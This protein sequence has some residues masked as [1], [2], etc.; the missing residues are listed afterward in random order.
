M[1]VRTT[2]L[3]ITAVLLA[4][5]ACSRTPARPAVH[6]VTFNEDIAPILY[7]HCATCH[8]PVNVATSPVPAGEVVCFAGAPFSV[9]AYRD[10]APHA[11][12]IAAA[13][14]RRQMPPWLP[15]DGYGDFAGARR[16]TDEQIATLKQWAEQGAPEGDPAHRPTP[17]S[18]PDGWQLG[19]PDL[20]VKTPKPFIVPAGGGD[21]FRNFVVP[22]PI[23]MTRYVRGIE[24]RADNPRMVHHASIGVDRLRVSRKLDGRD[25]HPGFASMPD[26]DDVQNVYGWSPGKAP[27]ME[28]AEQAWTLDKGSDLVVQMHL[29]PS[30]K[31]QTVR[32]TLALFFSDTPP[33]RAPFVIRL[34][35][36]SIDIPAGT[37]DYLV[38]DEYVLPAD[39]DAISIYPHAHYLARDMQAIA[40]LPDGTKRWLLWIKQWD[41]RWQDQYH[42]ATPVFLPAGTRLT[43]RYTYDNSAANPRN[44]HHPPER[45]KWGPRSSDEMAALWLEVQPRHKEDLPALTRDYVERAVRVDIAGAEMQVQMTPKDP[46][47]HNYLATKY[48]QARR[49]DDA[50]AQLNEA[51]HLNARDA[52]AHSNLSLAYEVQGKTGDALR[53][54]RIAVQLEPDDD[55]V[56]YNLANV[57][58]AVG[59]TT[60]AID[61]F[62]R[63]VALNPDNADAQFNLG[64]LLGGR[65]Q[66]ADA[67]PHLRRAVA[68]NPRN[69]DAHR[70]LGLALALSGKL[71]DGI[72]EAREAVSLQPDSAPA[73]QSLSNL[74]QAK[75]ASRR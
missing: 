68:L 44:L 4:A 9:L 32:P 60:E 7:D 61:E 43:M 16:L 69:A 28:P 73:Q 33:A 34:E 25:G 59:A 37:P 38:Q 66:L 42:Y 40:T 46:L 48:L 56:H 47:A 49:V 65:G 63:A 22:V 26:D 18:L 11:K 55:R 10:V 53:E 31:P 23:G 19:Q 57:L 75:A 1:R 3:F 35:S 67:V 64:V 54:A 72:A 74:L 13:V 2:L 70:N 50:I 8:R 45:V 52:E 15:A 20:V 27:Y 58:N 5:A 39:V 12:Q 41:F 14:A 17:P 6:V 71:D 24:L 29:L 30:G 62:T 51:L 21:L 36:K